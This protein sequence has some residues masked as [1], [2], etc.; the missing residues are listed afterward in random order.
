MTAQTRLRVEEI[1]SRCSYG[2]DL[3]CGSGRR[4]NL[5]QIAA[6]LGVTSNAALAA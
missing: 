3:H 4:A 2:I 5:P 1:V 6:M